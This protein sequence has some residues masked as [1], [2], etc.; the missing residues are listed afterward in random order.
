MS[1]SSSNAVSDADD[2]SCRWKSRSRT[3]AT[4]SE[5]QL[6]VRLN[7]AAANRDINKRV[8]V[9]KKIRDWSRSTSST[10]SGKKSDHSDA[11]PRAKKPRS[12][13]QDKKVVIPPQQK[14]LSRRQA[15]RDRSTSKGAKR[16]IPV[17]SKKDEGEYLLRKYRREEWSKGG[18]TIFRA[19]H[20][21]YQPSK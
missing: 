7:E 9:D 16:A 6:Q 1:A 21:V 15:S 13:G 17:G 8:L 11:S 14:E 3:K 19:N 4:K 5:E 2:S 12:K 20:Y 18:K 10:G